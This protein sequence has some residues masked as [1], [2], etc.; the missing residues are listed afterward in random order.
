MHVCSSLFLFLR[1]E[2]HSVGWH[3]RVFAWFFLFCLFW[4]I[5]GTKMSGV[6]IFGKFGSVFEVSLLLFC[7]L[8][9]M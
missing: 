3:G 2:C 9:L 5:G 6:L 8:N 4:Y 1:T 7:P